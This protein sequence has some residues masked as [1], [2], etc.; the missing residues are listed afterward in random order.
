MPERASV[1]LRFR[2]R[3]GNL[4]C[5][6]PRVELA[7]RAT[8]YQARSKADPTTRT[9]LTLRTCGPELVPI[10]DAVEA[11][12]LAQDSPRVRPAS[13]LSPSPRYRLHVRRRFGIRPRL[14]TL[15]GVTMDANG[16][17]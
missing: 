15:C 10:E 13:W 5:H 14:E 17:S 12:R 16:R 7:H 1:R 9:V 2:A 11:F 4:G 6:L 8:A 3:G